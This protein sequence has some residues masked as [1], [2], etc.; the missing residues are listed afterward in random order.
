MQ[1]AGD[2]LNGQLLKK[3]ATARTKVAGKE[4][5]T[6]TFKNKRETVA[7]EDIN[8]NEKPFLSVQLTTR[9]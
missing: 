8:A 6:G 1:I 5:L 4:F 7:V 3:A 2:V 9:D